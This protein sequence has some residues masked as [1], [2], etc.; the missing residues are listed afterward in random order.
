M[1]LSDTTSSQ[2]AGTDPSGLDSTVRPGRSTTHWVLVLL[3]LILLSEEVAYA[4]NLVTPALPHIAQEFGTTQIAWVSTAFSLMGAVSA[5]LF[6]KLADRGGKK[7]WLLISA[8]LMAMGSLVSL[9]APTFAIFLVG[10]TIEGLGLGIVAITYSLMRDILPRRIMALGVSLATAGIGITGILG[11]YIAGYLI[12]NHGYR[13]VFAFL[14]ALPVAAGI[15]I[16]LIVPESPVRVH[17]PINYVS[18][19]ILGAAFG[20]L[21]FVL[22]E[23]GTWGWTSGRTLGGFALGLIVLLLW[24]VREN[25]VAVPLIDLTVAK[26]RA[27][28]LTMG[29]NLIAQGVIAIHFVLLSFLV[30]LPRDLGVTYGLGKSAE[31]MAVITS[32]GGV[33]S[34]AMGFAVGW[35]AERIGARL[36]NLAGFAFI[37]AGSTMLALAH[38]TFGQVM[39]GY[40]VYAF[41]GGL[42][43][44]AIPN[45]VIAAVPAEQQAVSATTV[46]V[47]GSL[48]STIAVQ[49]SF[50][51]LGM[52]VLKLVQGSPIYAEQ[53]FTVIYWLS[54]LVSLVAILATIAMR[55]GNR[56]MSQ[57]A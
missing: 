13:G 10:R 53:G 18:A 21:L 8:G 23:G 47:V 38:D 5:P 31:E 16:A 56:P 39:A 27:M 26:S 3:V 7:K 40:T 24:G 15:A 22:G 33:A 25:K 30:Q 44:A 37:A 34:V 36:P 45:L 29:V 4:F 12:D 57:E 14:F 28:V 42:V 48:G 50:A 9:A 51:I 1:N 2:S 35:I 32:I 46:G 17:E 54:A 20:I 49:V 11:P 43:S 19:L 6:G 55:H 52:N 41:G